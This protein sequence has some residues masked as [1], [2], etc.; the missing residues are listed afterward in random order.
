M[1]CSKNRA[2][3]FPGQDE[4]RE[5]TSKG[6]LPVSNDL[7]TAQNTEELLD[8]AHP[9]LMGK[10]SAVCNEMK[11]AKAIVDEGQTNFA[12]MVEQLVVPGVA[13]P[14]VDDDVEHRGLGLLLLR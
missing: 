7:E 13:V 3:I 11:S 14:A 4:I 8:Q 12:L 6:I 2:D 9:F 10:V 1:T 5:L